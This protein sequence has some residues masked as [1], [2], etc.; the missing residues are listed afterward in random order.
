MNRKFL[1][2]AVAVLTGLIFHSACSKLDTTDIGNELIPA[3][4]NVNTFDTVLEVI[5]DNFLYTDSSRIAA[6]DIHAIGVIGNDPEFGETQAA[7]YFSLS[8]AVFN[9]HPFINR[10]SI[11]IDSI[12]LSLP[13]NGVYGDSNAIEQFEV[14]EI[15]PAANFKD[16]L[17]RINSTPFTLLPTVLG[18]KTVDFKTLNDSIV[19][20][21]YLSSTS[22]IA[23]TVRTANQLRIQLDPSFATKFLNF[24]TSN[25]YKNDSSFRSNFKGLAVKINQG[26]SPGANALAYFT[27]S[28]TS[29]ASL[30]FYGT[31]TRNGQ[32]DTIAPVFSFP[33]NLSRS[34]ANLITRTPANNYQVYL[35]NGN[36]SDDLVYL[37]TSPGSVATVRIPGLAGLSNRVVHRAELIL[38]KIPSTL[39]NIYTHPPLLFID[40]TNEAGDSTF[41]IRNDFILTGQGSGYDIASL[42]GLYKSNKYTFNLSRYVQSIVTKKQRSHILRVY[43]P[44]ETRPYLESTNETFSLYPFALAVSSPISAYRVVLGGGTHPTN[45]MRL[46]IIYSKI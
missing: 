31:F 3:V 7:A 23:D 43:A 9:A 25:Q 6:S 17:Y 27:L 2:L 16:S 4:D 8:P 10:D 30:T 37:Q 32:L 24:D 46:R 35:N 33:A 5:T 36:L 44:Y 14:F 22:T 41:T 21:N 13:F 11:T 1:V 38:E 28:G 45:K 29:S 12:V 42:E 18:S 15:D 39:D 19:Y 34:S 40:G 26:G 20:T